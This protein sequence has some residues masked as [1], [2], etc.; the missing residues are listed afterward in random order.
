ML[1]YTCPLCRGNTVDR[2]FQDARREYFRCRT[3]RLVFVPPVYYLTPAEARAVYDLHRN[4]PADEGYRHF[5]NRLFQPLNQALAPQSKGLDFGCGPGPVLALM[6]KEAGH[7]MAVY[8]PHYHPDTSV[9]ADDYDFITASEVLEH[10]HKPGEVLQQ[11]FSILKPG[12]I[13][14]VMTGF[15]RDRAAFSKWHYIR[16]LTHI[17]F[18]SRETFEWLADKWATRAIFLGD[19][20][21]LLKK[22]PQRR[23]A[24]SYLH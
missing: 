10:L 17:C 16:D 8:D 6:L 7:R 13:L 5:L 19:R 21:V 11:L 3:C 22:P 20:V 4:Y 2:F 1:S 14:G 15:A 23:L 12:G 24:M 9:L 18:F